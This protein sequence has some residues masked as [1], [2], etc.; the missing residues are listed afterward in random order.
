[1]SLLREHTYHSPTSVSAHLRERMSPLSV[2]TP[3]RRVLALPT[4]IR[5][6]SAPDTSRSRVLG[7]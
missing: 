4:T 3:E 6:S 2:G 5:S 7:A 1:M